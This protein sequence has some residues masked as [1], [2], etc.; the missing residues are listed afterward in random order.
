M[1]KIKMNETKNHFKKPMTINMVLLLTASLTV[2]SCAKDKELETVYRTAETIE[3]SSLVST[4]D[5]YIY[6]PS[7][8]QVPRAQ[9]DARAFFQGDEKLVKFKYS[10]KNLE[11]FELDS[12]ARFSNNELN[13]SPVITIPVV[14]KDYKCI[15]NAQK[16]CSQKEEENNETDWSNKRFVLPSYSDLKINE[17]N[18]LDLISVDPSCAN[19]SNTKLINY[20]INSNTLNIE[21][22]RTYQ[23]SSAMH[24]I[25]PLYANDQLANASFKVRYFYSFVKL[26]SVASADFKPFIY[27]KEDQR[28]FGFFKTEIKKLNKFYDFARIEKQYLANHWNPNRKSID[29]Y[30]DPKFYNEENKGLLTATEESFQSINDGLS[31]AG[32]KFQIKIAGKA[33]NS[34]GDIRYSSIN[35]LDEPQASGLLG[36]G[37]SI[38]NP[39]TGEIVQA[40]INMYS[41]VL[42]QTIRSTYESMVDLGHSDK[43]EADK[44]V[45]AKNS[46]TSMSS[47]IASYNKNQGLDLAKLIPSKSI[48]M[49]VDLSNTQKFNS[50]LER[51]LQKTADS[52]LAFTSKKAD[53]NSLNSEEEKNNLIR[54]DR[55]ICDAELINFAKIAKKELSNIRSIP[56]VVSSEGKLISWDLLTDEARQGILDLILP[57]VYTQTLVHEIGHTLGLRHNFMGSYDKENFYTEEESKELGLHTTP[58]YSS[59]M[60]YANSELN[61]LGTLGKYDVAALRYMYTRKVETTNGQLAEVKTSIKDMNRAELKKYLYCTDENAGLSS[62]CNRFDEG[63]TLTEVALSQSEAYDTNYK[64]SY[65]RNGRTKFDIYGIDSITRRKYADFQRARQI[66]EEYELFSGLFGKDLL[67]AGCTPEMVKQYPICSR[68]NDT[69]EATLVIARMFLN[70]IKTPDLSCYVENLSGENINKKEMVNLNAVI[71]ENLG[72]SMDH[73]PTGCFDPAVVEY[74]AEKDQKILAQGGKFLNS[75]KEVNPKFAEYSSDISIRG[76]FQDKLLAIQFLVTRYLGINGNEDVQGSMMDIKSVAA[77]VNNYFAHLTTGE[78]LINPVPFTDEKG[79]KID[80]EYSLSNDVIIPEA[81]TQ[82]VSRYF[83]FPENS[84]VEFNRLAIST[85]KRFSKS[86]DVQYRS[87][88]QA[89]TDSLTVVQANKFNLGLTDFNSSELSV[90]KIDSNYYLAASENNLAQK[91]IES[92]NAENFLLATDS[93][94][95]LKVFSLKNAKVKFPVAQ[96]DSEKAFS[97]LPQAMRVQLLKFKNEKTQIT[98]EIIAPQVGDASAKQIMSAYALTSEQMNGILNIIKEQTTLGKDA[99]DTEREIFALDSNLLLQHLEGTLSNTNAVYIKSLDIMSPL[100]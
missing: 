46:A 32:V 100:L 85:A 9:S 47:R 1:K 71:E 62:T 65:Y 11:I 17:V 86:N 26:K 52:R 10:E 2:L 91:M 56:G 42:T 5:L 38:T 6:V 43:G 99:T 16:E 41:G 89:F 48:E 80:V 93:N 31:K 51:E 75:V 19:L 64:Y 49:K 73:A 79:N 28:T 22:E 74:F 4:D 97:S 40:H 98:Y 37:P 24:C 70:I 44:K 78:K 25:Y 72:Y 92:I 13:S 94:L 90:T 50:I 39:L 59:I 83:G 58:V 23:T 63:S 54:A 20:E 27:E 35:L 33:A 61:S 15:E 76:N 67:E 81:S 69:R 66:F 55:K 14:Y 82:L 84:N 21:L 53:P 8:L 88:A 36:Y 68:I 95:I 57:K 18:T 7:T 96:T 29:F 77:E 30:L 60:D 87:Q 3:K 45:I 12:D 34:S